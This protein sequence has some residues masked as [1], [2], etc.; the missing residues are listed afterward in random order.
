MHS[1]CL[2]LLNLL[3]FARFSVAQDW[4]DTPSFKIVT[5]LK[6]GQNGKGRFDGLTLAPYYNGVSENYDILAMK[7]AA[8]KKDKLQ[9]LKALFYGTG[10]A[11]TFFFDFRAYPGGPESEVPRVR[12]INQFTS[13]GL[14]DIVGGRTTQV[15][16]LS[17]NN[18]E[19]NGAWSRNQQTGLNFN[20][21]SSRG[22][23]EFGG[24][25]VCEWWKHA[26]QLVMKIKDSAEKAPIPSSCGEVFLMPKA[27]PTAAPTSATTAE[28]AA[29]TA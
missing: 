15:V 23:I 29:P 11:R 16:T 2:L 24:W 4:K 26:P 1:I 3:L 13:W 5:K 14:V 6:P 18:Q 25:M 19:N 21:G 9:P 7:P 12:I 20:V 10:S 28:Q 8:I 17:N 22:G 27:I